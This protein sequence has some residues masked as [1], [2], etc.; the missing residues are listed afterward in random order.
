MKV[1][2]IRE[3]AREFG[4]KPGKLNKVD[5]VRRIQNEE[6]N[7]ACFGTASEGHCD[8]Q[9]CLWRDDCFIAARKL[10]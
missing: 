6:G 2:E 5:L 8:Q 7:F 3:I 9:S 1:E 4:V 10:N